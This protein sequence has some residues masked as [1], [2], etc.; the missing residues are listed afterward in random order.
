MNPIDAQQQGYGYYQPPPPYQQPQYPNQQGTAQ[1]TQ[2]DLL[3]SNVENLTRTV[4]VVLNNQAA[5][6]QGQSQQGGGDAG[7]TVY[8]NIPSPFPSLNY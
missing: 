7:S 6:Q 5:I 2:M 8:P 3:T 1:P 4:G